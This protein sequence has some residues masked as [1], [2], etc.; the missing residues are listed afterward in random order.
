GSS[1]AHR[2]VE[3]PSQDLRQWVVA[4]HVA[5]K[6]AAVDVVLEGGFTSGDADPTDG[7]QTRGTMHPDHRVGLVM[8][9]ETLAWQ[10]ARSATLMVAPDIAGRSVPGARFHPTNG[11]VAGA[12]Y[13]FPHVIARPLPILD[14]RFG[15]VMAVATSDVVDPYR[16]HLLGQVASFRGG[17]PRS[18]D[19]GLE[20][21]A[22][23]RL[24]GEIARGVTLRGGLEGGVH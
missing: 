7:V 16:F 13:L 22:S 21:D 8:F 9:P 23:I 15:A 2:T 18:R 19:L 20:L 5:R 11:G 12:L 4:A 6:A 14:L 1:T 10:T 17:D 24:R 3:S